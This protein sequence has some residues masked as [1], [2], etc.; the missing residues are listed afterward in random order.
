MKEKEQTQV[1]DVNKTNSKEKKGFSENVQSQEDII[2]EMTELLQRTQANFENYRKQ[3]DIRIEEMKQMAAKEIILQLLPVQDNFELA[4]KNVDKGCNFNDFVKGIELIYSQFFTLL[5]DAGVKAIAT[6]KQ[7]FNPYYHEALIKVES[8]LPENMIIEEFQ[9]GF[10]LHDKVI[11]HAKVKVSA[12]SA[13]SID[14]I[15]KKELS[16]DDKTE[17]KDDKKT[18]NKENK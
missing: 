11:R 16:A 14:K 3:N 6:D 7:I 15:S 2:R 18:E 12:G 5:S 17:N 8:D 9:K 1:N 4:L 10:T 13:I